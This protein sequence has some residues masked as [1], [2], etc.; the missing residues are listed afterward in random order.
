MDKIFK[1]ENIEQFGAVETSSGSKIKLEKL[2]LKYGSRRQQDQMLDTFKKAVNND[3]KFILL[4]APVGS[5]KSFA[6]VMMQNWFLENI[7][8]G[9]KFHV[10]TATKTL[11]QQYVDDFDFI[12]NIWGANN[13]QCDKYECSCETGK[14]LNK[15]SKNKCE[16]CPY[17]DA[18]N[19]FINGTVGLTNYH[20]FILYTMFVK[21]HNADSGSSHILNPGPFKGKK[22]LFLDEAHEFEGVLCDFITVK[23]SKN[24]LTKIGMQEKHATIYDGKLKNIKN[25]SQFVELVET[26]LLE[27]LSALRENIKTAEKDRKK[28][29]EQMEQMDSLI[30]KLDMFMHEYDETPDNWIMESTTPISKNG[31]SKGFVE[32]SA[33]PIWSNIYLDKYVWSHYDY[34]VMLSGTFLDKTVTCYL[35]GLDS[36]KCEY[37]Y[38]DSTFP[39]ENRKIFYMPVAKMNYDNKKQAFDQMV[40]WIKKILAKNAGKKGIIH[41][42]SFELA[43]WIQENIK[44]D[45]LLFHDS[46]N[47]D[48]VLRKHTASEKDTVL[49]SPSMHTGV[50]LKD[51]LS[52]FQIIIKVPYPS[53]GSEKIKKR[54]DIYP[55][56]YSYSTV[57][58]IVQS[59]GR[60]IRSE[61]DYAETYILDSSFDF[62][63]KYSGRFIPKYVKAAI[64]KIKI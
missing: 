42:V 16:G 57:S 49:C 45:R 52:R 39:V 19:N 22:V 27:D 14:E 25:I 43:R 1:T 10:L 8:K 32:I 58:D 2:P 34:V 26:H 35:N 47:R 6:V 23:I 24:I 60:S 44:D 18:R 56:Y 48:L 21:D 17:D 55:D 36:S 20:M 64:Q 7:D 40:P 46:A 33:Q 50:D 12:Q 63:Q 38:L 11:Q 61:T 29:A 13:Y 51:D 37:L 4:D 62:V 30:T 15:A 59:Y 41:T 28:A 31:D 5:G 54:K 3:T 53:L 9:A